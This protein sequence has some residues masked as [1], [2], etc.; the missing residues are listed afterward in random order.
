MASN[1]ISGP[2]FGRYD[3]GHIGV[4]QRLK[5]QSIAPNVLRELKDR[6][7]L[8]LEDLEVEELLALLTQDELELSEDALE[9]L[10]ERRRERKK[11]RGRA[12]HQDDS[13]EA[14]LE[15]L[16]RLDEQEIRSPV[17]IPSVDA[18]RPFIPPVITLS[19][20]SPSIES[21]RAA[22]ARR[23]PED[24]E[25]EYLRLGRA[26]R[27]A[28]SIVAICPSKTSAKKVAKDLEVFGEEVLSEVKRFGTS[29]IVA[30]P[31]Q[32]LTSIK[33]GGLYIFGPGE[34][35]H[36]GRDWST[37]RGAYS[38][39]QR[40]IVLGEELL[41]ESRKSGRSVV[42]H[43]F[44]HAFEDAW[45]KKRQRKF[46]LGVELWYRFEKSRRAF[47]TPYAATKP[48]EYFAES[49]EAFCDSSLRERLREADPEMHG[50]LEQL[51]AG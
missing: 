45:S 36:D 49:V 42:R 20:Y 37:V 17:E 30:P 47:I 15:L 27:I 23:E 25:S 40:V 50:Y 16:G 38:S 24:D 18:P 33:I 2:N 34:K 4:S 3:P 41:D 22:S 14:F 32:P 8:D 31:N 51:L 6:Y 11:K 21:S 12:R 1:S 7:Q 39:K 28:I 13:E 26:G 46:P 44:A 29:I 43:E 19:N 48:A 35:T 5:A 10:R 9:L